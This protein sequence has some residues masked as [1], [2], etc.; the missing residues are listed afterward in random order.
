MKRALRGIVPLGVALGLVGG[1]DMVTIFARGGGWEMLPLA[2]PLLVATGLLLGL[3]GWIAGELLHG[4][5][6]LGHRVLRAMGIIDM[7]A[8]VSVAIVVGTVLAAALFPVHSLFTKHR[9]GAIVFTAYAAFPLALLCLRIDT[10]RRRALEGQ[11]TSWRLALRA[12]A[13]LGVALALHYVNANYFAGLY[14]IVHVALSVG[15]VVVLAGICLVIAAAWSARRLTVTGAV[16]LGCGLLPLPLAGPAQVSRAPIFFHGT[17]LS[18]LSQMVDRVL[19]RDGDGFAG[20]LGGGDCD[21][22]RA[23]IH[24]LQ[25]ERPGNGL[26]DNCR[27]GD[28]PKPTRPERSTASAVANRHRTDEPSSL[29]SWRQ[30]HPKPNI[31][32]VFIDTLRVDHVGVYVQ[33]R[34]DE[35]PRAKLTPRLDAFAEQAMRFDQAR[36]TAPR[37]PHAFMSLLRGRFVGRVMR[38]RESIN[39]PGRDTLQHRLG[40]AG[41]MTYARLVGQSWKRFNLATGWSKLDGRSHVSR[42]TGP[43]VVRDTLRWVHNRKKRF[44]L[45]VHL[46]DPHVPY[47]RHPSAPVPAEGFDSELAAGYA[48]EI[49]FVDQQLGVLLDGLDKEGLLTEAVVVVFSDHGEN[50]GDHGDAGG[51]HGVSLYDEVT[52][53]PLLI[54]GPMLQ[55]GRV[56]DPVSIADIAPTLLTLVGARP[57]DAPDGRS[58]AGYL[59]GEPP[60]PTFTIS[61]FYDFGH[62]L[63][64]VVE[65]RHKLIDDVRHNVRQLFDIIEDPH[66]TRDL[67]QA[68]PERASALQALLD[69]W[70]ETRADQTSGVQGR[71]KDLVGLELK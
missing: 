54:R 25:F 48:G 67:S 2:L 44:F 4:L 11:G 50:L 58:L 9:A 6:W 24:P 8:S 37:T 23:E 35:G 15:A 19:D 47:D 71:C 42:I 29:E 41:Y 1:L 22:R 33:A 68:E 55:A 39:R 69:E 43:G 3:I 56:A 17:E 62:R 49:A 18:Y 38:C 65:G 40:D 32:L 30:A 10:L 60:P 51:H 7:P 31:V 66:E 5:A 57:L 52:H 46:A 21:D 36:T 34:G 53:V 16:W 45:T 14:N 61:E 64:A 59:L 63:R 70:V 28:L 13:W 12:G 26:D 20:A 27:L